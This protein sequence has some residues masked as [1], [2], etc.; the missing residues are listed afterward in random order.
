MLLGQDAA[1]AAPAVDQF[2]HQ[3]FPS[4][5]PSSSHVNSSSCCSICS[6]GMPSRGVQVSIPRPCVCCMSRDS[7]VVQ[8]SSSNCTCARENRPLGLKVT[9]VS[10]ATV[11]LGDDDDCDGGGG[12]GACGGCGNIEFA[13]RRSC[14]DAWLLVTFRCRFHLLHG[15]AATLR[16]R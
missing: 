13:A 5:L 3:S 8:C 15:I 1:A 7:V 4:P 9:F 11:C 14:S 2:A 6:R 12:D 10:K 16:L